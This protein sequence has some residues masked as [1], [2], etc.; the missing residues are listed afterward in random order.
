MH[1]SF[2]SKYTADFFFQNCLTVSATGYRESYHRKLVKNIQKHHAL[3]SWS[4]IE[5]QPELSRFRGGGGAI[6][7]SR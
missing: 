5:N 2:T 7:T 6:T 4:S 1:Y 3:A